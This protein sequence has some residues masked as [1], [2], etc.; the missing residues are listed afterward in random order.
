[1]KY[2][3]FGKTGLYVSELSLGA[4]TFGGKGYWEA[5]GRLSAPEAQALIGTALDAGVNFIDT[6]DVYSEGESER[7]VG[8]ALAALGRQRDQEL[9]GL[10]LEM[11]A[12]L[13]GM[14]RT[15][16]Q[17]RELFSQL[18]KSYNQAILAKGQ[19]DF[20]DVR[21]GAAAVPNPLPLRR[22]R[23][24]KAALVAVVG[25][26]LGIGAALVR[27]ADRRRAAPV[28]HPAARVVAN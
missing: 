28:R 6:A 26:I 4:M 3:L 12:R 22:N 8:A 15:I 23:L 7:F 9:A 21:V 17:Q 24:L 5:I 13:G 14:D 25:G 1:M 11:D 27:E 18:S 20:E 10:K 19:Q 16:A 2:R